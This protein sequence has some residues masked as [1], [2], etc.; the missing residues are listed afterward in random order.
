MIRRFGGDETA[1]MDGPVGDAELASARA[2]ARELEGIADA[3]GVAPTEGFAD[4]VMGAVA[5]EPLPAPVG[6]AG[7]AARHGRVAAAVS[8]FADAWRVALGGGSPAGVRA[9]AL[10]V[11]LVVIVALG[12][13]GGLALVGS[14]NTRVPVGSPPATASL[15]PSPSPTPSQSPT[16][17]PAATPV[18]SGSARPI[19]TPS[20]PE[21]PAATGDGGSGSSVAPASTPRATVGPSPTPSSSHHE[22]SRSPEPTQT[23]EPA[24]TP[25]TGG[26][27]EDGTRTPSPTNAG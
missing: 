4:R 11:V 26:A 8:A 7:H 2:V 27:G 3:S 5:R 1:G 16:P 22:G 24:Q 6:A 9:Q 19:E 13:I 23:P 15:A 17:T 18:P 12:T 20:P 25:E 14:W 10:A 21:T